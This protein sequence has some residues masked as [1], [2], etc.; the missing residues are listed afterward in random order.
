MA[1][2]HA[3]G[4]FIFLQLW[5]LGRT[6]DAA[7]LKSEDPSFPYVSASDIPLSG[8]SGPPPRPLTVPEIKEYV[9]L[10]VQAAKNAM[11]AGFDG[12]EV[13]SASW[14]TICL[15]IFGNSVQVRMAISW[16]SSCKMYLTSARTSMAGASR[17]VH[18]LRWR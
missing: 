10:Y 4:S 15:I 5:A 8:M 18:A 9:Q 13:H 14:F 16:I 11:E 17:I 7:Q 1:A 12:V 2:V 6:A 3:K